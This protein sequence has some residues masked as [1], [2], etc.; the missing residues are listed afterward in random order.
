MKVVLKFQKDKLLSV[1]ILYFASHN[2]K[3]DSEM[4]WDKKDIGKVKTKSAVQ[5]L[6]REGWE[7]QSA[8]SNQIT[9]GLQPLRVNLA[10]HS[11][12]ARKSR[13][14]LCTLNLARVLEPRL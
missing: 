7:D 13:G 2:V 1:W 5:F 9:K 3:V 10:N 8:G 14:T 6:R 11:R 4:G 12:Q